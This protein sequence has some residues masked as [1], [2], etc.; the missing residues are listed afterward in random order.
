MRLFKCCFVLSP[1]QRC[2]YICNMDLYAA[3]KQMRELSDRKVPFSLA[4]MSCATSTQSS[5]G[6][7]DVRHARLRPRP[8]AN[9]NRLTELL[10]EYVDLDTGEAR[11]FYRPLLLIFNGQKVVL[12]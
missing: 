7:V 6:I 5:Q 11:Q 4:F 9:D 8:Q 10:E 2:A 3:I 1:G 12:Q